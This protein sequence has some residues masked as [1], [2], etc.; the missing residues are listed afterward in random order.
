V[1]PADPDEVKAAV[2]YYLAGVYGSKAS[3]KELAIDSDALSEFFQ[4]E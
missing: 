2:N 1:A 3:A 4:D